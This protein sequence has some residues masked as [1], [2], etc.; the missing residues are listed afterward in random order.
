MV[1]QSVTDEQ[2]RAFPSLKFGGF[3]QQQFI[4]DDA[5]NSPARFAIHRARVGVVGDITDRIS[6]NLVGGY[7]EPPNNTP[8]LVN[9]FIDF[10]I[11]PLLQIRTGQFLLPF[12]L[13]GP[14]PIFL[15]PSIERS[16][17]IRRLS[18]FTM[19]RD[20][21]IRVSGRHSIVNYAV[22]FVNGEG[23]N[24]TEQFDPKDLM[25]RVGVNLADNFELGISGH[26]GQYRPNSSL[27]NHEA[28]YKVGADVNYKGNP[29]F[30]RSEYIFRQDELSTGNSREMHGGY[31]LGGYKFSENLEAIAR[32]EYYDP[33]YISR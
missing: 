21:G 16:N 23:A 20:V 18:T 11:D 27:D 10:D 12:G 7:A 17:A 24:Q 1:A 13:E 6:I 22:A 4:A 2:K 3:L 9:A 19:F 25:G 15:N 5:P 8:R 32:Y 29:V 31:L 26:L 14:Q 30:L 33:K 28:R